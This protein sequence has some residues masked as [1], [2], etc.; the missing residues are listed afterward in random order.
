MI[1]FESFA[2]VVRAFLVPQWTAACAVASIAVPEI[3]V[4]DPGKNRPI[5]HY[6]IFSLL[7]TTSAPYNGATEPEKRLYRTLGRA[8]L[9]LHLKAGSGPKPADQYAGCWRSLWKAFMQP[10]TRP[11]GVRFYTTSEANEA[12]SIGTHTV[13]VMDVPF[14]FDELPLP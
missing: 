6:A 14:R 9:L 5:D 2:L 4:E 11:L 1:G 8:Q 12:G 7:K 10:G 13:W 3:L